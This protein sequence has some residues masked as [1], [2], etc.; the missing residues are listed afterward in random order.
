MEQV[1]WFYQTYQSWFQVG[2]ISVAYLLVVIL[3]GVLA[4]KIRRL[5]KRIRKTMESLEEY[6]AGNTTYEQMT[7]T[8]PEKEMSYEQWLKQNVEGNNY[9]TSLNHEKM[10]EKTQNQLIDTVLKEIF[11]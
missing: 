1:I 6:M 9:K 11:S 8:E 2:M 4:Q 5:D 3:L 10:D 7:E